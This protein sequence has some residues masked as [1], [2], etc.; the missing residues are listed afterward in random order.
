MDMI[1]AVK[2]C[3]NKYTVI[4]GRSRR[5]EYWWWVLFT[6][7]VSIVLGIVDG[8]L[9]TSIN[10]TTG[11]P[12]TSGLLG[13]LFSLATLIPGICVT[14]RRL[15]DTN[16]SG[17]WQL[18]WLAIIVGWIPLIIWLASKGTEGDNR[19]GPNPIA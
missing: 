1:T 6:I 10:A 3:F 16:R 15:H 8:I 9:F 11:Q 5:A 13:G 4:S 7:I 18:L 19:F 2:T 17:W 12:E 14:A